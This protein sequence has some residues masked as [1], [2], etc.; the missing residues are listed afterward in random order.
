MATP[1]SRDVL[2]LET[3]ARFAAQTGFRPGYKLDPKKPTDKA[4]IPVWMDIF[5][6]VQREAQA[7]TLVTTYDKPEV[8][9]ALSDAQLANTVAAAHVDAAAKATDP[10]TVQQNTSAAA[11]AMQVASQKLGEAAA[12]QPSTASP[13]LQHEAAREAAKTP[14]PPH[15]SAED[16]IAHAQIQNGQIRNGRSKEGVL[17]PEDDPWDP[18]YVPKTPP[19]EQA[20]TPSRP[21]PPRPMP[22]RPALSREII[23]EVNARFWNRTEYKR[24]EKLDMSIPEDREQAKIWRQLLEEVQREAREGRL[25]FTRSE[26]TPSPISPVQPPRPGAPQPMPPMP[27]MPPMQ[28][29]QPAM[30][31][32]PTPPVMPMPPPSMPMR[33]MPLPSRPSTPFQPMPAGWM[34]PGMIPPWMQPGHKYQRA[35]RAYRR[36]C[37][38]RYPQYPQRLQR[39]SDRLR[40][41]RQLRRQL[42]ARLKKKLRQRCPRRVCRLWRRSVSAR[43]VSACWR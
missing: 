35:R 16:Q 29:T 5:R 23:D 7:G 1:I 2:N 13:V 3:D 24:G 32:M 21:A 33:P 20:P 36:R 26:P 22:S 19:R 34:R 31:P 41:R 8:A 12:R 25:T 30:P 11:T 15:A 4:M 18:R 14:P 43:W 9:Q 27:A 6:K 37:V 28:P 17:R 38:R 40:F 39:N 42:R 10:M